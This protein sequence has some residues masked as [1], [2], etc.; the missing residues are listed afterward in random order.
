M[1]YIRDEN[2]IPKETYS[3]MKSRI[4]YDYT[5]L[6]EI[7][8]DEIGTSPNLYALMNSNAGKFGI[9]DK[10][11]DINEMCI[12]KLFTMNINRE[13]SSLNTQDNS[14]YDLTRIQ[15]QA[16]WSTNHLLMKIF[17]DTKNSM[18][19]V[20]GNE[21]KAKDFEIINGEVEFKDDTIILTSLPEYK[22]TIKL[23]DSED[24]K[25]VNL[26]VELNGNIIGSQAIYLRAS[27][28]L[29][30]NLK[31]RIIN[32]IIEVTESINGKEEL[33]YSKDLSGD[34]DIK[35][36]NISEPGSKKV[37]LQLSDNMLNVTLD[38]EVIVQGL[39]VN[40]REGGSILLE[41]SWGEDVDSEIKPSDNIYD[42]I[43]KNLKVTSLDNT[44]IYDS[45]LKGFELIKYNGKKYLMNVINWFITNL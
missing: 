40:S 15:P 27:E 25:D 38:G 16:Y 35:D 2:S 44:V 39:E 1:D 26:S 4:E 24:C 20:I 18:D 23:K 31:F 21:E 8:N 33:L 6:H 43:F 34:R 45:S 13:G 32:N 10:V 7:Y 12:K 41:S 17:D 5:K 42:G 22:G 3:E 29:K 19:F 9:N 36:I 14:I 30:S 11:S 28:D 37:N